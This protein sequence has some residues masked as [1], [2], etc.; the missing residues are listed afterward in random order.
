MLLRPPLGHLSSHGTAYRCGVGTVAFRRL[1]RDEVHLLLIPDLAEVLHPFRRQLTLL[2]Q[3]IAPLNLCV[4]RLTG[5]EA[6]A[7]LSGHQ[8]TGHLDLH[9]GKLAQAFVK[10]GNDSHRRVEFLLGSLGL[11]HFQQSLVVN[12]VVEDAEKLLLVEEFLEALCDTVVLLEHKFELL[13]DHLMDNIMH[14]VLLL[15]E[16]FGI[17]LELSA[18]CPIELLKFFLELVPALFRQVK[19]R[20]PMLKLNHRNF[21]RFL[22]DALIEPSYHFLHL[23]VLRRKLILAFSAKSHKW[24]NFSF[25]RC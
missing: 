19:V 25:V 23:L 18:Y 2:E 4:D 1:A 16:K 3:V 7:G 10:T 17:F 20:H 13:G 11:T 24:F 15:S 22:T 5:F 6:R 12:H 8:N 21:I 14:L 9:D